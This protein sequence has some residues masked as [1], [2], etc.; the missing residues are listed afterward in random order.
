[1]MPYWQPREEYTVEACASPL[2]WHTKGLYSFV[3]THSTSQSSRSW[4]HQE[5]QIILMELV[6]P[7]SSKF[8]YYFQRFSPCNLA[9]SANGED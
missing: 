3:L 9:G 5:L 4:F 2:W 8:R 7:R 6:C 1:M